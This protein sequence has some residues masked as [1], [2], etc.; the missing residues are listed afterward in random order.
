MAAIAFGKVW[1]IVGT[2]LAA[3]LIWVG[4]AWAHAYI[5]STV[6]QDGAVL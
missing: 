3:C 6:P 5:D 4:S 2:A 1:R